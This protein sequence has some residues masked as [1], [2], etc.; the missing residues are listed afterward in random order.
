MEILIG[1]LITL[2]VTAVV[3]YLSA[4]PKGNAS[5]KRSKLIFLGFLLINVVV[6][7]ILEEWKKQKDEET[8][9]KNERVYAE[10]KMQ[11][12]TMLQN[13]DSVKKM[14]ETHFGLAVNFP[15]RTIYRIV[16]KPSQAPIFNPPTE[17]PKPV[18]DQINVASK[19]DT[20]QNF[21]KPES[22]SIAAKGPS[23]K[24]T[25]ME[26]GSCIDET[27]NHQYSKCFFENQTGQNLVMIKYLGYWGSLVDNESFVIPAGEVRSTG[28][29]VVSY[30]G[31]PMEKDFH[32]YF[33]TE[34]GFECKYA[35][36]ITL[37]TCYEYTVVLTKTDLG[38]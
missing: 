18:L 12:T 25:L 7:F 26:K 9:E 19:T 33:R 34:N 1:S 36:N 5:N 14:L 8:Q 23:I 20:P 11:F 15:Q 17:K 10:Q 31:G 30:F 16:E 2:T 27:A 29:L 4:F 6:G 32:F 13:Q 38:L 24:R 28:K 37:T 22:K 21:F 35:Y 3:T